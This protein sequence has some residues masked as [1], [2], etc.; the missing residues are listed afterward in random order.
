M[1]KG[2]LLFGVGLVVACEPL[3]EEGQENAC[4]SEGYETYVSCCREGELEI[5]YTIG[6]AEGDT[7]TMTTKT[8]DAQGRLIHE[9]FDSEY[10]SAPEPVGFYMDDFYEYGED[11][12]W[13]WQLADGDTVLSILKVYQ[14]G[15]LLSAETTNRDDPNPYTVEL[16]D[17]TGA[18]TRLAY[19]RGGITLGFLETMYDSLGRERAW[20]YIPESGAFEEG[21]CR[22]EYQDG[23]QVRTLV[24]D[25]SVDVQQHVYE[26]DRLLETR[27]FSFDDTTRIK[28]CYCQD[29]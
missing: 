25:R 16:V 27:Y 17:T 12:V 7:L 9:R 22:V 2:M 11:T 10:S 5:C 21:S 18:M 19:R 28:Y 4:D 6:V 23:L 8:F 29:R 26:G 15:Y 24:S 1:I 13:Q 3:P 20:E 14:K